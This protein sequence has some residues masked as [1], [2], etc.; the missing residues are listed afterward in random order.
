MLK[1]YLVA[2][3]CSRQLIGM[4]LPVCALA[5]VRLLVLPRHI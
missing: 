4:L 2:G 3:R 5:R 1:A